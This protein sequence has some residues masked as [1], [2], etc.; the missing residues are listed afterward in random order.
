VK[1]FTIDVPNGILLVAHAAIV[2]RSEASRKVVSPN[3]SPSKPFCS[4]SRLISGMRGEGSSPLPLNNML[5]DIA[6]CGAC[7]SLVKSLT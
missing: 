1:M 4:A 6:F 2:A 3:Q 5:V 7:L